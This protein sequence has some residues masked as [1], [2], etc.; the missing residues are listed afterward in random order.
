M[1]PNLGRSCSTLVQVYAFF[2]PMESSDVPHLFLV[3]TFPCM[4]KETGI[5]PSKLIWQTP[6]SLKHSTTALLP[7][8]IFLPYVW[9]AL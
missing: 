6:L 2:E 4:A 9:K 3:C 7:H 8:G 5:I 1:I